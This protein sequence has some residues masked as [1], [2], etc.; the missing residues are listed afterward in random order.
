[1]KTSTCNCARVTSKSSEKRWI[2]VT[3]GS[4]LI[5]QLNELMI[6]GRLIALD[7]ETTGL[8]PWQDEILLVQLGTR[9]KTLVIDFKKIG[10]AKKHLAPLLASDRFGKLGHN[11]AFDCAFLEVNGLKVR[12]PL[13]DTFLASKILTAGLPETKG[14]NGLGACV[15]RALNVEL[16][17]KDELQKSFIGHQGAFSDEQLDYAAQDVGDLVFDLSLIHI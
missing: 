17:N 4:Q 12:G 3:N 5:R 15:K 14:L 7:I 11:L 1:M 8:N 2:Y 10:V 6:S 13:C 16:E 9:T